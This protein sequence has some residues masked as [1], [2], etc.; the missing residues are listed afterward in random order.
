MAVRILASI[1]HCY[2]TL[3]FRWAQGAVREVDV[4]QKGRRLDGRRGLG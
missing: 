1:L 3:R 2:D 4:R